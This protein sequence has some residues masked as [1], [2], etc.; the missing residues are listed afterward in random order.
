MLLGE[1]H[2]QELKRREY[3]RALEDLDSGRKT[4]PLVKEVMKKPVPKDLD[5]VITKTAIFK[6]LTR[7]SLSYPSRPD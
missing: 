4:N 5:P 6:A 1:D 2:P 3:K 7:L